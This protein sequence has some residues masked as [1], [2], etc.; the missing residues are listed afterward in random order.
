M[1]LYIYNE[2]EHVAT[3]DQNTNEECETVAAELYPE[4]AWTYTPAF[5]AVDGLIYNYDAEIH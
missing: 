3:I 4:L 1:K 2:R 5:G